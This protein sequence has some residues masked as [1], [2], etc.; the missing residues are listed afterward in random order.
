MDQSAT[1]NETTNGYAAA[2]DQL[3]Q[4]HASIGLVPRDRLIAEPQLPESISTLPPDQVKELYD[5]YLAYYDFLTEQLIFR[6]IGLGVAGSNLRHVEAVVLLRVSALPGK[7]NKDVRDASVLVDLDYRDANEHF[8]I[9]SGY[10]KA[11]SEKR[12]VCSKIMDRLYRELMLRS[13]V[14]N[15]YGRSVPNVALMPQQPPAAPRRPWERK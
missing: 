6:E 4:D 15:A 1:Q 5:Q 9:V 3:E 14:N 10:V 8:A 12:N 13:E 2:L 11:V 7:S